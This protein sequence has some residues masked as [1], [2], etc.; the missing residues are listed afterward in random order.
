MSFRGMPTADPTGSRLSVLPRFFPFWNRRR[1]RRDVLGTNSPDILSTD[2]H[3]FPYGRTVATSFFSKFFEPI[4]VESISEKVEGSLLRSIITI[5]R[6]Y[7]EFLFNAI[8]INYE[9]PFK[10]CFSCVLEFS[11]NSIE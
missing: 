5:N 8:G 9:S 10:R 1:Q 2:A 3:I 7:R 4:P 6:A 11:E